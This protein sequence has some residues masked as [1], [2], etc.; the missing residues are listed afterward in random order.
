MIRVLVWNEFKHERTNEKVAEIYPN[1]IHG[2]IAEF[3]GVE[4]DI[5]VRTA[6]LLD[7][8]CGITKEILEETDVLLWWGHVQ[9]SLVPDDVVALVRDAVLDGMG[10]IFLHSAHHSKPFKAL[11]GTSC[12]LTWRESG[13]SEILR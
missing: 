12:N 11:M 3:L 2:A 8:N 10:A 13:D 6:T 5:K 9:H 4:D 7:E 1:G